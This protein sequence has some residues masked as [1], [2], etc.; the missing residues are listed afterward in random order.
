[1]RIVLI[2]TILSFLGISVAER[3]HAQ[4][5]FSDRFA[6]GTS[7]AVIA[8]RSAIMGD[9]PENTLGWIGYAIERGVDVIHINPQL[10][11]DDNYILMHDNTLNRMTNVERVY[12]N[13]PPS[14]PTREQR[15]GRDYVRDYTL[16]EIKRL[17]IMGPED[18]PASEVSSLDEAIEFID[19]R[20]LV[21]LGLKSY[22]VESLA[23]ALGRYDTRNLMF[24][25]LYYSGTD[26]TKLRNLADMSGVGVSISPYASSDYL[27]DLE[28]IYSQLGPTL[29]SYWV[30]KSG[31]SPE[32]IARMNQLGLFVI[33][34]G[35]DG[36]EDYAIIEKG[37]PLPWR[38]ILDQGLAAATD[39]P[40]L[41]LEIL[42]R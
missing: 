41:V 36:P 27:T 42:G 39:Q 17:Q 4:V 24:F 11:A 38:I 32:L 30:D 5:S 13:G 31:L 40:D 18:G 37:D 19:G 33:Y 6:E 34:S 25:E 22:E 12:P 7:A 10:T 23:R 3:V 9:F 26:Q 2:A 35:W 1:M 16:E 15:G 8:H 21:L 14:G 28:G 20:I 29:K